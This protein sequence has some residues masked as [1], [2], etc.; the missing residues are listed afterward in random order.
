MSG[1]SKNYN[2][3]GHTPHWL[4][5]SGTPLNEAIIYSMTIVPEFQKKYKLQIVN[6]IFLTDGEGHNLR[7]VYDDNGYDYMMPKAIKAETLVIRDP[8]T[9]NQESVDLK[10]Y[11]YDAQSKALIKLL[12]ARTNSN[13][14]GFYIISGRDFGRKVQQ[15]FP[16]QNNH[17]SLKLDFRKNKFMVLQNSGY[18]EYYIL[19]SG[20]LD[21]EEDATFEVKENST[22]KGIASA[23]AKHNVNR[24]GSRVVLNRFIKLVA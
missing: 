20:G 14:I 5:L 19:R 24:I 18:D 4:S 22:I 15:W 7:E 1:L 23:F 21:T 13:V 17:E 11:A 8:I 10:S 16:K 9:K 2:R 6:T 3:P 12:R